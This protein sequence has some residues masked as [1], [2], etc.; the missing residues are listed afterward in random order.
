[1]FFFLQPKCLPPMSESGSALP[2]VTCCA[3]VMVS[4]MLAAAQRGQINGENAL[5]QLSS[6]ESSSVT[7]GEWLL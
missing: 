7:D 3:H 4:R 6:A 1:M 2:V 5:S